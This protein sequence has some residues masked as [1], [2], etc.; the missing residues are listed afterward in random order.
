MAFEMSQLFL[1]ANLKLLAKLKATRWLCCLLGMLSGA[2]FSHGFN[3]VRSDSLFRY[4][5]NLA[6]FIMPHSDTILA[7]K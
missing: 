7:E 1:V 6:A 3:A 4:Q 2:H 5:I